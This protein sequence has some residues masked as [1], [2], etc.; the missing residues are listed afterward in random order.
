MDF[1]QLIRQELGRMTKTERTVAS[2]F[3]GHM[4]EFAFSTLEAIADSAGTSTTSVIRFCRRLGFSGYKEFQ[5][6]LQEVVRVQLDLPDKVERTIRL[7]GQDGLLHQVIQDGIKN[8][9]ETFSHLS[10]QTLSDA[11]NRIGHA[12]RVFTFG[13]RESVALA[14]YTMTRLQTVRGSTHILDMSYSGMIEQALDLT[15]RDAVIYFLFH[16]YTAQS[17]R[18]LPILKGTGA[19][20]ILVT[21]PPYTA[22]ERYADVLLPCQMETSGLK[23]SSI[24][25]ICLADYFCNAVAMLDPEG[26]RA[27]AKKT[28]ALMRAE[29]TLGS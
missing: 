25:P 14:H 17:L 23:N 26:M 9:E 18:I 5:R 28:E 8:L 19:Q 1:P 10:P 15:S 22:V 2:Y 11:V 12:Q 6:S 27:R 29:H 13:M 21:S 24:A 16:R 20:I 7:S 4:Q 3:E